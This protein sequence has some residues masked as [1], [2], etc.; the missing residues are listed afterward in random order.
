MRSKLLFMIL[1]FLFFFAVIFTLK[2]F[3]EE[4]ATFVPKNYVM[5]YYFHGTFRCPTCHKLE[6]Y[7]KEAIEANFKDELTSGKIVFKTVNVDE[8]SNEH[9]VND[10]QLYTKSLMISLVRGGKEEK[11][12]N[13]TKIWGYAGNKQR[14][15]NYVRDEIAAFLK[16]L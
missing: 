7:S 3:S 16:E 2:C 10:Y 6:Q 9:F 11:F 12:K 13:L 5:A 8:K 14:F 1:S 4:A 15:Y